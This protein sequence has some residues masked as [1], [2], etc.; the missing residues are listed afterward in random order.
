MITKK[1]GLISSLETGQKHR[2]KE[3]ERAKDKAQELLK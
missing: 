1:S 3:E 2:H